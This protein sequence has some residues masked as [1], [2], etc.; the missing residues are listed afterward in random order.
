MK[1]LHIKTTLAAL[2][3]SAT[4]SGVWAQTPAVAGVSTKVGQLSDGKSLFL[5]LTNKLTV[6]YSTPVEK[7]YWS[8]SQDGKEVLNGA[9]DGNESN[10]INFNK[11]LTDAM[12]AGEVRCGEVTLKIDKVEYEG[13]QE[14]TDLTSLTLDL[15]DAPALTSFYPDVMSSAPEVKPSTM[16]IYAFFTGANVVSCNA[17]VTQ[18]DKVLGTITYKGTG[19]TTNAQI[20][21]KDLVGIFADLKIQR[22]EWSVQPLDVTY[23]SKIDGAQKTFTAKEGDFPT[24]RYLYAGE[25]GKVASETEFAGKTVRSWYEPGD[26]DGIKTI[27]FSKPVEPG[28]KVILEYGDS[29]SSDNHAVMRVPNSLSDDGLT[30]TIDLCGELRSVETMV[31]NAHFTDDAGNPVD[32]PTKIA[33]NISSLICS[34]GTSIVGRYIDPSNGNELVLNGQLHYVY[35]Y[36]DRTF[37]TPRI[38]DAVIEDNKITISVDHTEHLT[39]ATLVLSNGETELYTKPNVFAVDGVITADIPES[40]NIAD[41]TTVMLINAKYDADDG[42]THTI[43]PFQIKTEPEVVLVDR[44]SNIKAQDA[45][46]KVTLNTPGAVVTLNKGG[47]IFLEDASGAILIDPETGITLT[48]GHAVEGELT[49]VYGGESVFS[50]DLAASD[51]TLS[52][53]E[54]TPTELTLAEALAPERLYTLVKLTASP[55]LTITFDADEGMALI[56]G[57]DGTFAAGVVDLLDDPT[58][59]SEIKSVSGIVYV[60]PGAPTPMI[61]ITEVEEA[62]SGIHSVA[63]DTDAAADVYTVGGVKVRTA[64][65]SLEGLQPGVYI[66]GNK[67]IH[68]K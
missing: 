38:T 10:I 26:P 49:G 66:T 43:R 13:G 6:D 34:D 5:G 37:P 63:S 9:A 46:T 19:K 62:T 58:I 48:Q 17:A 44:I 12:T 41:I 29:E 61:I 1:S 42:A 21:K 25:A 28:M 40:V 7:T 15:T 33:L 8:L 64:G 11:A 24:A 18:N 31:P 65:E 67:K 39:M 56:V 68:V 59:P 57:A 22:G 50:V 3:L 52:P 45:G 35:N 55:D 30:L 36:S 20:N 54:V 23:I 4:A 2:A 32:P 47:Y 27:T 60:M 16:T 53:A 51:Y 14:A